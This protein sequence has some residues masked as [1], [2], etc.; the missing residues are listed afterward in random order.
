MVM[1]V[2]IPVW[3][4]SMGPNE[5]TQKTRRQ[6]SFRVAA[7]RRMIVLRKKEYTAAGLVEKNML[8]I[9]CSNGHSRSAG[10]V[11]GMVFDCPPVRIALKASHRAAPEREVAADPDSSE[12]REISEPAVSP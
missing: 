1:F 4:M 3:F 11:G 7:S 8:F 10:G 6:V 2:I 12:R 5:G 9:Q